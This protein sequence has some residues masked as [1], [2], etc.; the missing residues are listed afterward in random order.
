MFVPSDNTIL[1]ETYLSK[2]PKI[3]YILYMK[4]SISKALNRIG[5]RHTRTKNLTQNDRLNFFKD[6]EI[7]YNHSL[8]FMKNRGSKILNIVNENDIY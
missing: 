2:I 3:H 5:S 1:L 6:S 7:V 8:E 4:T